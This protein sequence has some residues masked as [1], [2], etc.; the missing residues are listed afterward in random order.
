MSIIYKSFFK[1]KSTKIYLGIFLLLGITFSFLFVSKKY[2]IAKENEAYPNSFIY[3]LS[4]ENIDLTKEKSIKSFN[5][6]IEVNCNNQLT[7]V[8]I[9]K[10]KTILNE[11]DEKKLECHI[12]DYTINYSSIIN[13]N[14]INNEKIYN[15][16]DE[17]ENDYY[18]F[19]TLK[20]WIEKDKTIKVLKD[21]YNVEINIE[22]YKIDSMEYK[23]IIFIFDIFIKIIYILFVVLCIISIFNIIIDE[24]KNNFLY[25]SLG[26]SK[27][28]IIKLTINKIF[29]ILFI[30]LCILFLSLIIATFI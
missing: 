17:K 20:N 11:E 28:K 18:Y 25:Y 6:A 27:M 14:L 13:V 21:K 9:T 26:Y 12:D 8:F 3:F 2:L 16:L 15:Y 1:K 5:K 7:H 19:I 22:E 24:S 23:D 29:L 4:K 30:P 10:D